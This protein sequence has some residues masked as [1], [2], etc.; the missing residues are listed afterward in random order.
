MSDNGRSNGPSCLRDRDVI[1]RLIRTAVV[2][3]SRH[4][5]KTVTKLTHGFGAAIRQARKSARAAGLGG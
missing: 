3:D 2:D 4:N 1:I 5:P